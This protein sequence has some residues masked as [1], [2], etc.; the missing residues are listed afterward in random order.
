M[1]THNQRALAT[2]ETSKAHPFDTPEQPTRIALDMDGV[3]ADSHVIMADVTEEKYGYRLEPSTVYQWGA[4]KVMFHLS[5]GKVK[6]SGQEFLDLFD[7]VWSRWREI[8]VMDNYAT[9]VIKELLS[10]G[11]IVDI[12]TY[13][14]TRE[15]MIHKGSWLARNVMPFLWMVNA[16]DTAGWKYELDYDVFVEDCP[17]I[18]VGAFQRGRI[19]ILYDQPWN[20]G[21]DS[22]LV[23]FRVQNLMPVP[24]MI[25]TALEDRK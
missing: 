20:R 22:R 24:F 13:S 16:R 23:S 2:E 14:K 1:E 21:V 9:S 6:I 8:P 18:A 12:V 11:Y 5:G 7:I 15:Q 4:E 10:A 3:L 17:H 25:K 19:A